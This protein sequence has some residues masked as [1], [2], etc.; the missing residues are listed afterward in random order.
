MHVSDEICFSENMLGFNLFI[1]LFSSDMILHF[2]GIDTKQNGFGR[3]TQ[4]HAYRRKKI[5][6]N[7]ETDL[8]YNYVM[9]YC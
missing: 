1:A 9:K 5:Q 4:F 8:T 7:S 3:C 6:R 2:S